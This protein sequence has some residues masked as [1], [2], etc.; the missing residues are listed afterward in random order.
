MACFESAAETSL[1]A[2]LSFAERAPVTM[3][4]FFPEKRSKTAEFSATAFSPKN[5]LTGMLNEIMDHLLMM[6]RSFIPHKGEAVRDRGH[7]AAS[8]CS[9]VAECSG[10]ARGCGRGIRGRDGRPPGLRAGC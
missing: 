3:K 6:F 7:R 1:S 4:A 8:W 5:T 9:H 2:P 10:R